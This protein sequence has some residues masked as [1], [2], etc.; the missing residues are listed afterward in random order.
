MRPIPLRHPYRSNTSPQRT[1]ARPFLR[2]AAIALAMAL[3]VGAHAL[4][5]GP[6]SLTGFAKLEFQR[7]SNR[8]GDCQLFPNEDKQRF[9]ADDLVPGREYKTS[10]SH[11]TLIQPYLGAKFD[12]GYGF[13][14]QG[15]LSQRWRNGKEDIP[16]YWYEKN[17][18]LS[19]EDYGSLRYGAM[20]TRTWSVADYPYGS[21][22][23]VSD[24]WGASGAGYGLLTNALRY[25]SRQFDVL[26]GDLVLEATFDPGNTDFKINKPKF[27]E[28][29]AQYHRG[30]LV[31]DAMVQETRNGNP[32][33]WSHGPFS[34][35]TPN[36]ADDAKV[37]SSGQGIAMAM[38]RY[39]V[40]PAWEV[41]G[42]VRRNR[43]SGA[44]AVITVP[45]T[46]PLW[47]NMFNVDWGGTLYGVP[48]AGYPA[49]SIDWMAG[50]RYRTGA[51]VASAGMAY[52]G[53]AKTHNPSERGQSNSALVNTL[54]LQYDFGN[55]MQV[56]GLA[57]MVHYK[58]K[59]LAPISM[60]GNAAFTNVD[61]RIART[62]NWVGLGAVYTF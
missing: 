26:G 45:G 21:N 49:T 2:L 20:T 41:S 34:S 30:D 11:V 9:W 10:E 44:Y 1:A 8:C 15:L 14:L 59:G 28:T 12:L 60:P 32:Q 42:G 55:G 3:P 16:G 40:S 22:V 61:S 46:Q 47:N 62:G 5:Y 31:V 38:A 17:V 18:A 19:H 7:G 43:W 4:D 29:Y 48:N 50:L 27:W 6:F 25:T 36:V 13:K 23:G 39:Q 56:Y 35:V 53:K 52:L 24:V 54:G 33:A 37:G 58:R 51:W 57:G